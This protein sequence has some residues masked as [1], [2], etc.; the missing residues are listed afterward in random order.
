[1][2][3]LVTGANSTAEAL[4]IK[5]QLIEVT[6]SC[7][8]KLRKW[9]SNDS[10]INESS[11]TQIFVDKET[12]KQLD[13]YWEPLANDELTYFPQVDSTDVVTKLSILSHISHKFD[14]L[15]LITPIQIRGKVLM[16]EL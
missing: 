2:D 4:E 12:A 1:M 3:D 13:V 9:L 6:A 11:V 16:Q 5:T 7:G 15:R 8:F 14:P 10:R